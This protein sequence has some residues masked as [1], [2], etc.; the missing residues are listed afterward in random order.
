MD[1][2]YEFSDDYVADFYFFMA[3]LTSLS[4]DELLVS[5][6]DLDQFGI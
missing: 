5:N 4:E 1:I 2:N 3:H 6:I